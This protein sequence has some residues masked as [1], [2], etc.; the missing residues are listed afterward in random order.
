MLGLARSSTPGHA[1]ASLVWRLC[2]RGAGAGLRGAAST[3]AA[4][5]GA[6]ARAHPG[7]RRR[8]SCRASCGRG[9]ST[10][11]PP[12]PSPRCG[13][14]T[15]RC[16]PP[17]RWAP[18]AAGRS[19]RPLVTGAASGGCASHAARFRR[20]QLRAA[21]L[22]APRMFAGWPWQPADHSPHSRQRRLYVFEV[23]RASD[24]RQSVASHRA[25]TLGAFQQLVG[26]LQAGRVDAPA[27]QTRGGGCPGGGQRRARNDAACRAQSHTRPGRCLWAARSEQ[28]H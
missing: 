8:R 10:A 19:H 28:Q 9:S 17:T 12:G 14:G 6:A 5:P 26:W 22:L 16:R 18:P 24:G 1:R 2:L 3:Q 25:R 4:R 7:G 23:P 11:C 15:S 13:R 27:A 21:A 20:A